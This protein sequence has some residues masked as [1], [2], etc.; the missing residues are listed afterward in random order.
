MPPKLSRSIHTATC[1]I[2]STNGRDWT[3]FNMR[4]E[5]EETESRDVEAAAAGFWIDDETYRF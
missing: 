2:Q 5:G 4:T 1:G 3:G